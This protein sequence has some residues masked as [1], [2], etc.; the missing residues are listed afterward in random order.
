M[1]A[2]LDAGV[3]QPGFVA[4][5]GL[6]AGD[7][8]RNEVATWVWNI[9]TVKFPEATQIVDLCHARERLYDLA[10]LLEFMLGDQKDELDT[11]LSY[12][13]HNAPRI[14]CHWFRSRGLFTG[15]GVV[16]AGC[17]AA[18]GPRVKRS[19]MRWT[20]AGDAVHRT[21]RQEQPDQPNRLN[22]LGHLQD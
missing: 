22:D 19:G 10:R 5:Y 12:F 3:G 4:R 18:I 20:I 14:R 17:K 15:S 16:E 9:A 7:D 1:G 2:N 13:E 11:A 6:G 8:S 21:T